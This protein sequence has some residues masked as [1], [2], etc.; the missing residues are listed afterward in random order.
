MRAL[1]KEPTLSDRWRA[2]CDPWVRD[3]AAT[4]QWDCRPLLAQLR[5]GPSPEDALSDVEDSDIEDRYKAVK[6]DI[7]TADDKTMPVTLNAARSLFATPAAPAAPAAAPGPRED[8]FAD[9]TLYKSMLSQEIEVDRTA[10]LD[11]LQ[12][13][14]KLCAGEIRDPRNMISFPD[15]D[16]DE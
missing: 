13:A 5:T 3:D 15:P 12:Y 6:I 16:Q 4:G 8:A 2:N 9:R 1:C 11:K 14:I 7:D 10:R